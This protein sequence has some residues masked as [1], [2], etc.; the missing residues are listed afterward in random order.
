M[1]LVPNSDCQEIP[2]LL[3]CKLCAIIFYV[4]IE[5]WPG[6]QMHSH[7]YRVPEPFRDQVWFALFN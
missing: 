5:S 4:G 6:Q 7:N 1:I 2:F 3:E